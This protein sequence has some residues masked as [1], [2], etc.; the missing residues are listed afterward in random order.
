MRVLKSLEEWSAFRQTIASES[1]IGFVPTMGALHQGHATLVQESVQNN[2]ITVVS[3]FVN[4]TQFGPNEDLDQYP[5]T[6][7]ADVALLTDLGVT[8]VFAPEIN[9]MYPFGSDLV[10]YSINHLNTYLCGASRPGH[11]EGVVQVVHKLFNIVQPTHAY[12]GEKDFQQLSILKRFVAEYFIP[13]TIVPVPI[14]REKDGLAMSSRNRYMKAEERNQAIY[15]N[16]ALKLI[17]QKKKEGFTL[18]E[19]KKAAQDLKKEYPIIKIDYLE[20]VDSA[21][22]QSLSSW[23]EQPMRAVMAAWCGSPRLLDNREV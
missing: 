9:L 10:V 17:Q 18:S 14:V 5:R 23:Q 4:P 22:L 12:F 21:T 2:E 3:I 15:L 19:A 13:V 16:T 11:F 20:I 7:E 6:L 8:A 1:S